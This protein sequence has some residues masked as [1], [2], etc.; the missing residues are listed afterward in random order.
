MAQVEPDRDQLLLGA[1]VEV[2]LEPAPFVE[3]GAHDPGPRPFHLRELPADLDAQSGDLDGKTGSDEQV[4]ELG[5]YGDPLGMQD[6]GERQVTA[7]HRRPAPRLGRQLGYE[8]A[9]EVGVDVLARQPVEDHERRVADRR[10]E[11]RPDLLGLPAAGPEAGEEV[12]DQCSPDHLRGLNVR[13]RAPGP[14]TARAEREGDGQRGRSGGDGL[15]PP[16][17][18]PPKRI[19]ATKAPASSTVRVA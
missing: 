9:L 18:T 12:V 8:R 7:T 19:T 4:R 17:S 6:R 3:G 16:I 13:R 1:V 2:A 5:A 15:P 11:G 14:R 10:A